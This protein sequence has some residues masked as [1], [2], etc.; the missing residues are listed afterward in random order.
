[1]YNVYFKHTPLTD[2]S[3]ALRQ[4]I[5][6]CG[7]KAFEFRDHTLIPLDKDSS[8]GSA[9]GIVN[10]QKLIDH[11]LHD[12]L[13]MERGHLDN[14]E[15]WLSLG[16]NGLTGH[17]I[18]HNEYVSCD[19][20][21]KHWAHKIKPWKQTNSNIVLVCGQVLKDKTLTD[22]VDYNKWLN[23]TIK[24][25]KDKGYTVMFRPHPLE[26]EY[27]ITEEYVLSSQKDF[28][29][30]LSK[31]CCV[32]AWSSTVASQAV[33]HGTPAVTFSKYSMAYDVTSHTLDNLNYKPD[34][35]LWGV[36]LAYTMWNLDELVNGKA[37]K[38]LR[39][40]LLLRN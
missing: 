9:W 20:W 35:E 5:S 22:C 10:A 12:V 4:G 28:L 8:V 19:R 32:V 11:G 36:R 16:W 27:A 39:T 14:R 25:L 7:D 13:V 3:I 21:N 33:F 37:W 1:M 15:E 34:R 26:T 38:F 2:F 23:E 40:H 17:G 31:V 30:E 29:K 6:L 18:Y 24:T